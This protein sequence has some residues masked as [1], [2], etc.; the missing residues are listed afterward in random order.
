PGP[1]VWSPDGSRLAFAQNPTCCDTGQTAIWTVHANGSHLHRITPSDGSWGPTWSPDGTR[2]AFVRGPHVFT[3]ARDGSDPQR[4]PAGPVYGYFIAWNP[5]PLL[6]TP[7]VS[8]QSSTI[9]KRVTLAQP[10]GP[11]R[12]EGKQGLIAVCVG[13]VLPCTYIPDA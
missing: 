8:A 2:I 3:V 9:P 1:L 12:G 4:V 10:L 7:V 13:H 6:T 5:A 11:S